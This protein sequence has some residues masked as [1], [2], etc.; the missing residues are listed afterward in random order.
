MK[1]NARRGFTI[2]EL[3]IVIAVIGVLTAVLVPTF[4]SLIS[5]AHQSAD[6]V[7]ARNMNVALNATNETFTTIDEVK[8]FLEGE[9]FSKNTAPS[10]AGNYYVWDR[11][12]NQIII[13]TS[14]GKYAKGIYP[15]NYKDKTSQGQEWYRYVDKVVNVT[16]SE[17]EDYTVVE[18]QP[19]LKLTEDA[20]TKVV[21]DGLANVDL[22]GHTLSNGF[23]LTSNDFGGGYVANG[24]INGEAFIVNAPNASFKHDKDLTIVVSSSTINVANHSY[25]LLGKFVV[26]SLKL[27][28]VSH[29]VLNQEATFAPI[30]V[31]IEA[32]AQPSITTVVDGEQ[33]TITKTDLGF[34]GATTEV[35]GV[36]VSNKIE[37]EIKALEP[38]I[39]G[40]TVT[41]EQELRAALANGGNII[42]N[43]EALED[44]TL[45]VNGRLVATKPFKM[46]GNNYKIKVTEKTSDARV[47]NLDGD[48]YEE[49]NNADILI[50]DVELILDSGTAGYTRGISLYGVQNSNITFDNIKVTASY[51]AINFASYNM[52][53]NVKINNSHLKGWAA[54]NSWGTNNTY[55]ITNSIL[56]GI[57]DKNYGSS[58][59]FNV[60]TIDGGGM[61]AETY[62]RNTGR[63][64]IVNLINTTI[65]AGRV[66]K[67]A[68]KANF[69]HFIGIQYK[70]AVSMFNSVYATNCEF[71][72]VYTDIEGESTQTE[73]ENVN[74]ILEAGLILNDD[75]SNTFYWN[76]IEVNY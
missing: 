66:E 65:I 72:T 55:T 12:N 30:S 28:G 44:G 2:V 24:R 48:D 18:F 76:G 59:A 34:V 62:Q 71:I 51:Y 37:E 29:V 10:T 36:V 68:G 14:E 49:L 9:G 40:T 64:N 26:T 3:V 15:E 73:Y 21:I 19:T 53:L 23:E 35:S 17:L 20:Q 58:N 1:R 46:Y 52:G 33:T 16:A 45:N 25:Y 61:T 27:D 57:N 56:E 31:Q 4:S 75:T 11:T 32:S 60:I 50:K 5:R 7:T 13:A 6:V 8:D 54:I 47:I 22:T 42:L 43:F 41:N 63:N 39:V 74:D 38:A 69:Q 70:A 67:T